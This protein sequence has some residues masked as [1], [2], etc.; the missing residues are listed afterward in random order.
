MIWYRVK[1]T[2]GYRPGASARGEGH[3]RAEPPFRDEIEMMHNH[4]AS[5]LEGI[6]ENL[7]NRY[8]CRVSSSDVKVL[9][10][11]YRRGFQIQYIYSNQNEPG[12]GTIRSARVA[13]MNN[14][15]RVTGFVS[16][17]FNT[18]SAR[19]L[20]IDDLAWELEMADFSIEKS[21]REKNWAKL[22]EELGEYDSILGNSR[23]KGILL[24]YLPAPG[25][26]FKEGYFQSIH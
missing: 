12:S 23:N 24:R 20:S 8:L 2:G 4:P 19:S 15:G 3:A 6:P 22:G 10:S 14:Q 9:L 25:Y 16:F 7:Q 17:R 11:Q 18:R 26:V 21:I 5:G 13:V 1:G